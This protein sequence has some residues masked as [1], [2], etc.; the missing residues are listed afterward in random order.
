M[1]SDAAPMSAVVCIS[2]EPY[3]YFPGVPNPEKTPVPKTALPWRGTSHKC[4]W[5][6]SRETMR[7][8]GLLALYTLA[9]ANPGVVISIDRNEGAHP[10]YFHHVR[11]NSD[12]ERL[13]AEDAIESTDV[14][15]VWVSLKHPAVI[16]FPPHIPLPHSYVTLKNMVLRSSASILDVGGGWSV[17]TTRYVP[18]VLLTR[19]SLMRCE[20]V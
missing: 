16:K 4:W 14:A 5:R 17:D 19:F 6:T 3:L 10:L 1:A 11:W 2:G 7:E 18:D 9:E 12:K 13:E 15:S 8:D 20:Q